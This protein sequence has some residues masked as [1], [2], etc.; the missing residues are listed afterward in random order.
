[1]KEYIKSLIEDNNNASVRINGLEQVI[2]QFKINDE[3]DKANFGNLCIAL[4]GYRLVA[5]AT[6]ALLF[7]AKVIKS[8]DGKFYQELQNDGN[9]AYKAECPTHGSD[10]DE[11]KEQETEDK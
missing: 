1:M 6:E 7:N 10:F 5:D 3:K 8:E 4:K 9:P 2:A 11:D